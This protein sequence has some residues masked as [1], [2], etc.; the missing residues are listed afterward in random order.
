MSLRADT[1]T[2]STDERLG[3]RAKGLRRP[4]VA[5]EPLLAACAAGSMTNHRV[6]GPGAGQLVL[7][8]GAAIMGRRG[9]RSLACHS[10]PDMLCSCVDRRAARR[11]CMRMIPY[12]VLA[13][14][15]L[16]LCGCSAEPEP[17]P[18]DDGPEL[19]MATVTRVL[20]GDTVELA[21]GERVRY[22]LVDAPE[23]DTDECLSQE[24][25]EL[26]RQLVEGQEV[27]LEYDVN[28]KDIYD[29]TLAYVWVRDLMVNRHLLQRGYVCL[30]DFGP[31]NQ[32]YLEDF[33]GVEA[34]AEAAG[35]GVWGLCPRHVANR[36]PP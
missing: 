11:G 15:L 7:S 17:T 1:M 25:K 36:C 10:M 3:M 13:G 6:L 12:R 27:G 5:G 33:E 32:R 14:L 16:L 28:P 35:A 30:Y 19:T 24:A 29:R 9:R 20:D 2:T 26:N 23:T 22:L 21:G 8:L 4:A 34:A 31:P 18:P